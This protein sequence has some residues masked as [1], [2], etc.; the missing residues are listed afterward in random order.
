MRGKSDVV[1]TAIVV[2]SLL[3]YFFFYSFGWVWGTIIIIGAGLLCYILQ[4]N[5]PMCGHCHSQLGHR[6]LFERIDGGPDRRYH[7]NPLICKV[8]CS[9][10]QPVNPKSIGK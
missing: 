2:L 5:Q 9:I 8:C 10:W 7:A 1:L 6:Y 3:L 4:I